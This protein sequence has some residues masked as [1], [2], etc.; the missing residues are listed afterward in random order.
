MA[1]LADCFATQ[2]HRVVGFYFSAT[3]WGELAARAPTLYERVVSP[4]E[5]DN[6]PMPD[7]TAPFEPSQAPGFDDGDFPKMPEELM[8]EFVPDEIQKRWGTL[9]FTIFSVPMLSLP[10]DVEADLAH[11]FTLIGFTCERN[12]G[13]IA[14]CWPVVR[15]GSAASS[16]TAAQLIAYPSV[17]QLTVTAGRQRG[18]GT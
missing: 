5:R 4:L 10:A 11:A 6:E 15:G 13:L 12:D 17:R 18:S 3:T 16:G 2:R 9:T 7:E 8:S 14:G 1:E